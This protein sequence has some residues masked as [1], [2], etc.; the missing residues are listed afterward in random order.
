[1]HSVWTRLEVTNAKRSK[2]SISKFEIEVHGFMTPEKRKRLYIYEIYVDLQL[3][4]TCTESPMA[5]TPAQ[6]QAEPTVLD[7]LVSVA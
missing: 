3:S 4:R 6:R 5:S 1:M 7:S 2:P